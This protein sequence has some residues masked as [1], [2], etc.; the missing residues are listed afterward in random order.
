MWV[1]SGTKHM[2]W[3]V[4]SQ[5]WVGNMIKRTKGHK[6]QALAKKEKKR[7]ALIYVS[8]KNKIKQRKIGRLQLIV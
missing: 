4:I 6:T 7:V 2:K 8:I 5:K 3:G 1:W